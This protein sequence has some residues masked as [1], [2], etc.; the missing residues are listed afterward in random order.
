M[1]HVSSVIKCRVLIT[2]LNPYCSIPVP[3]SLSYWENAPNGLRFI[4]SRLAASRCFLPSL[5]PPRFS[6]QYGGIVPKNAI[7]SSN[8]GSERFLRLIKAQGLHQAQGWKKDSHEYSRCLL[9]NSWLSQIDLSNY[10]NNQPQESY[11]CFGVTFFR[12][13]RSMFVHRVAQQVFLQFDREHPSFVFRSARTGK[14]KMGHK[15]ESRTSANGS[16]K[17]NSKA[18]YFSSA[19]SGVRNNNGSSSELSI[20]RRNVLAFWSWTEHAERKQM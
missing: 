12:T 5:P 10:E 14:N 15:I 17:R 13:R 8:E 6:R 1:K 7:P 20:R 18:W 16:Q 2:W 11:K 3:C 4:F 19:S 9:A